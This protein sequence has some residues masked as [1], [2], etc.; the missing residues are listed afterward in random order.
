MR[1]ARREIDA[2][3]AAKGSGILARR[4]TLPAS[5]FFVWQTR[6]VAATAVLLGV[7]DVYAIAIAGVKVA[8]AGGANPVEAGDSGVADVAA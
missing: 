1:R 6:V 4:Q 7:E 8:G 5:T 3:I 2:I